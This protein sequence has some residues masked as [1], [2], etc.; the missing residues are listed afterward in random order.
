M[1][2]QI[3]STNQDLEDNEKRNEERL[4]IQFSYLI[5]MTLEQSVGPT[6]DNLFNS[7]VSESGPTKMPSVIGTRKPNT[8]RIKFLFFSASLRLAYKDITDECE[9]QDTANVNST[10]PQRVKQA[11]RLGMG[12]I[13]TS[14]R[15]ISHS[16]FANVQKIEQENSAPTHT[17]SLSSNLDPFFISSYSNRDR[18]TRN[19]FDSGDDNLFGGSATYGMNGGWSKNKSRDND[20]DERFSNHFNQKPSRT[21]DLSTVADELP[22][23]SPSK[24]PTSLSSTQSETNPDLSELMKKFAN[25]TSIS[26]DAFFDR[27]DS[28]SDGLSRFQG[29]SSISSDDY[30]GRPKVRQ[31]QVS[32]ELQNIKDGVKQSVTKVAGRLS[33]LAT[34]VVHTLQ[35]RFG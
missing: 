12:K 19:F 5:E 10:D 1:K 6:V 22:T 32:N 21:R 8:T 7:P 4:L 29:S 16:A 11:E 3:L 23:K 20:W 33:N 14:N 35:D 25:A 26:S 24:Q 30:F 17:S 2:G 34:D 28:E 27:N 13:G 15:E 18:D 9:R 31:S